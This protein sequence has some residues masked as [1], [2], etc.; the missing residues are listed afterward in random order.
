MC[1]GTFTDYPPTS[2]PEQRRC[3]C[4]C[5]TDEGAHLRTVGRK[6]GQH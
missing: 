4:P 3:G 6:V 2:S 5:H 1:S